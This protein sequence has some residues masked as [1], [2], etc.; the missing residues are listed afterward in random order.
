MP[1]CDSQQDFRREQRVSEVLRAIRLSFA[2]L[3]FGFVQK[4]GVLIL[5][6]DPVPS[7]KAPDHDFDHDRDK[8]CSR[9][10]AVRSASFKA[11]SMRKV[12]VLVSPVVVGPLYGAFV[13]GI[14]STLY[15]NIP[16]RLIGLIVHH[17]TEAK[18]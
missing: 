15:T 10:A 13:V 2:R 3:R 6:R 1:R 14:Y 16:R 7:A 11:S 17:A 8:R 4:R 12:S 9:S 5:D 18:A